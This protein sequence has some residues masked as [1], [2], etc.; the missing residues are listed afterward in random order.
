[1]GQTAIS[2]TD[3][4]LSRL[5]TGAPADR[6]SVE[7]VTCIFVSSFTEK[8]YAKASALLYCNSTTL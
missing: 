4:K 5:L 1:M 8:M 3:R 7:V 2:C 6:C